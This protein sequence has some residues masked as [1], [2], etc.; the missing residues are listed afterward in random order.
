MELFV[1]FPPARTPP[2]CPT[3]LFSFLWLVLNSLSPTLPLIYFLT[4]APANKVGRWENK[5]E[6]SPKEG[7]TLNTKT[8]G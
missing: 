3:S 6:D 4:L 2:P 1:F 8:H 5:V 7:G